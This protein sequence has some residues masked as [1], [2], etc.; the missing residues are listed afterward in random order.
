MTD[1]R[2]A[3]GPAPPSDVETWFSGA[4]LAALDNVVGVIAKGKNMVENLSG[5]N[6]DEIGKR[7]G[8]IR[9]HLGMYLS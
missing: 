1:P 3:P 7:F 6:V 8:G 2:K 4:I 5:G 9:W